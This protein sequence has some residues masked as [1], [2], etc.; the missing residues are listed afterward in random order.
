MKVKMVGRKMVSSNERKTKI[1]LPQGGILS[2]ILWMVM[3]EDIDKELRAMG[4]DPEE[5]FIA[6]YADDITIVH[7]GK[8]PEETAPRQKVV[9]EKLEQYFRKNNHK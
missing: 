2:P 1:G 7:W 4:E 3:V 5:Y 9:W 6:L 8:T